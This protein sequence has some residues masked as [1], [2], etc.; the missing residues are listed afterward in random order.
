[1]KP[2]QVTTTV[3]VADD[4]RQF[5]DKNECQT[6]EAELNRASS[7]SA[8]KAKVDTIECLENGKAPFGYSYIDDER[9][10]Y[11][12]YR[13][14]DLG[15]VEALNSFFKIKVE[16][17]WDAAEVVGEWV[18]VEIDGDYDT[19]TGKEDVYI[20]TAF[21]QSNKDLLEFYAALGYDVKI[22]K[23]ESAVNVRDEALENLWEKLID[24]PMDA[25]T[26]S[27]KQPFLQFPKGTSRDTI[28]HWFDVRH[29]KGIAYLLY[30]D[31][32]EGGGNS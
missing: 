14:K 20:T 10:E 9:Y 25:E 3:Y 27:I 32:A 6:Y 21:E 16:R 30:G 1:M 15:E 17:D 2:L 12:W 8:L 11:R 4:G 18:C 23:Q 7:F 5:E 28:W 29:S 26:E 31:N 22:E 24:I 19:Y 13:P